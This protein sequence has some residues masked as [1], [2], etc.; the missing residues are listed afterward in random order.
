[1]NAGGVTL[2]ILCGLPDFSFFSAKTLIIEVAQQGVGEV[3]FYRRARGRGIKNAEK[4]SWHPNG[5][6]SPGG[7]AQQ[8][9]GGNPM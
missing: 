7:A 8:N 1:M 4:S 2:S 3:R 9:I 5:R 6:T